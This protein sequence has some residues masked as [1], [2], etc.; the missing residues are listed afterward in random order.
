LAVIFLKKIDMSLPHRLLWSA[1]IPI[2]EIEKAKAKERKKKK[3]V[4]EG[5]HYIPALPF[6]AT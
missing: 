3:I 5:Y 6:G 4:F 1:A 2:L